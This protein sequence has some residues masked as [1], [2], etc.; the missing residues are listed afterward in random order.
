M[1]KHNKQ[2]T[3]YI[4][5]YCDDTERPAHTGGNIYENAIWRSATTNFASENPIYAIQ[6]NSPA[7]IQISTTN[8]RSITVGG[9]NH[10]NNDHAYVK[11]LQHP[12]GTPTPSPV[13]LN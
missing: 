5:L 1:E 12:Q 2:E 10:W 13:W 8:I 9:T 4:S 6:L 11:E 7:K 3:P